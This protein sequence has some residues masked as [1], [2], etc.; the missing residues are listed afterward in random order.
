MGDMTRE[1][2]LILAELGRPYRITKENA[3]AMSDLATIAKRNEARE[4]KRAVNYVESAKPTADEFGG[5]ELIRVRKQLLLLHHIFLR[6]TK[7][8]QPRTKI[9]SEITS[10]QDRLITAERRLCGQPVQPKSTDPQVKSDIP[11]V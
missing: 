4:Y 1:K 8:S 5:A 3:K 6:E 2:G 7:R 9:L 11:D 10:A